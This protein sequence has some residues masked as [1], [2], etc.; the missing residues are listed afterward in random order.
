MA[1]Q[2]QLANADRFVGVIRNA[3]VQLQAIPASYATAIALYNGLTAPQKA[4]FLA[5]KNLDGAE[6]DA[7][8]ATLSTISTAINAL[9]NVN[10]TI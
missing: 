7:I 3:V 2:Q 8:I 5:L 6:F 9:P 1:T 4:T 10:P